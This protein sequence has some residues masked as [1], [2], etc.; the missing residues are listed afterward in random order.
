MDEKV[1]P[2]VQRRR[3]FIEDERLIIREE[4]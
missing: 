2:V 3:K 4:T 1:S